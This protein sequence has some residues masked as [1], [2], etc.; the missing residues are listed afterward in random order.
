MALFHAGN[1]LGESGQLGA[2]VEYF[3][4]LAA[5]TEHEVGPDHPGTL[6]ALHDL[7]YWRGEM[8]DAEGTADALAELLPHQERVQGPDHP[9]TLNLRG[10][11]A[12]Y[13]GQVGDA[14]GAAGAWLKSS[15]TRSAS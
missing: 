4:D 5:T 3:E 12:Y 9:G 10:N 2:A 13:R 11:L 7:A 15:R 1:S 8:G 14:Q 6:T